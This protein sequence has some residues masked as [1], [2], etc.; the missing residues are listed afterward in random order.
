MHGQSVDYNA[1]IFFGPGND[2]PSRTPWVVWV[3]GSVAVGGG[4]KLHSYGGRKLHSQAI[5]QFY[6]RGWSCPCTHGSHEC[7][8]ATIWSRG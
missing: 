5:W 1:P 3:G 4:R 2:T 7:C 6:P 8:Y